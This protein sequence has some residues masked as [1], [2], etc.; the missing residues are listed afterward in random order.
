MTSTPSKYAR[1]RRRSRLSNTAGRPGRCRAAA[2]RA[3]G[4]ADGRSARGAARA[5]VAV[6]PA[7]RGHGSRTRRGRGRTRRDDGRSREDGR[8]TDHDDSV[9]YRYRLEPPLPA[10]G[11]RRR[12]VTRDRPTD[13]R[14]SQPPYAVT[15]RV[16]RCDVCTAPPSGRVGS[17]DSFSR[18]ALS[19]RS[20]IS[21]FPGRDEK[22]TARLQQC[23]R[24]FLL[25][26]FDK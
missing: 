19:L 3:R 15:K 7:S 24:V 8:P 2:R 4:T 18:H 20:S 22:I 9:I 6:G 12:G 25:L 21:S 26:F 10:R 14:S 17:A 23:L 16:I 11:R 13:R 1:G 5:S